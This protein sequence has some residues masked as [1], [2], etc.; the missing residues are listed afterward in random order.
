ML[1]F[2]R[3]LEVRRNMLSNK[4]RFVKQ[5]D[6]NTIAQ[7]NLIFSRIHWPVIIFFMWKEKLSREF[8]G[9]TRKDIRNELFSYEIVHKIIPTLS[10]ADKPIVKE[11]KSVMLPTK[12]YLTPFGK[13]IAEIQWNILNYILKTNNR[14]TLDEYVKEELK[15]L[16]IQIQSDEI[17]EEEMFLREIEENARKTEEA[18]K[19][20]LEKKL[21][22]VETPEGLKIDL[23]GV[24]EV[25]A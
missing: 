17:D 18:M 11:I 21:G 24:N 6:H 25:K 5:L 15:R 1:N 22:M 16:E 2:I 9:I 3:H 8:D 10:L 19:K 12:Y 13:K 14:K 4:G 20:K 23:T 7:M